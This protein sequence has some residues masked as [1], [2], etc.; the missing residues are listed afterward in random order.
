MYPLRSPA[1]H[2][3][4]QSGC[5]S[6]QTETET[7]RRLPAQTQGRSNRQRRGPA[8]N[9]RSEQGYRCG[10]HGSVTGMLPALCGPHD[11]RCCLS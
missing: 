9:I 2:H 6:L 8:A 3:S 7:Q 10:S 5:V 4:H 11:N 1:R